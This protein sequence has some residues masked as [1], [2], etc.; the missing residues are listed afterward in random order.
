[1]LAPIGVAGGRKVRRGHYMIASN[2]LVHKHLVQFVCC[3]S[4]CGILY[5]SKRNC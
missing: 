5:C 2:S 4:N 1:M 3:D